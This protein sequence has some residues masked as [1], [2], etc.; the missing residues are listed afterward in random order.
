MKPYFDIQ[1]NQNEYTFKGKKPWDTMKSFML[2]GI[3][4]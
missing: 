1:Q 3:K 2:N 4:P